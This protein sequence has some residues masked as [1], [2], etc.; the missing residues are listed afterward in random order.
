MSHSFA[1]FKQGNIVQ[2][3]RALQWDKTPLGKQDDWPA[4]LQMTVRL[5][6]QSPVA[7]VT[8]WGHDGIMLYND[9]CVVFAGSRH[10]QL[11]G[12]PVREG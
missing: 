1:P 7:M 11:L 9:A 5:V 6:L 12:S 4:V 3:I 8:I 10:P 2:E